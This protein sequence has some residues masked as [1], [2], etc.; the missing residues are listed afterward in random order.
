MTPPTAPTPPTV[1]IPPVTPTPPTVPIPPV[2]ASPPTAPIPPVAPSPPTSPPAPAPGT[3]PSGLSP[4]S[5]RQ[6]LLRAMVALV[7]TAIVAL[8]IVGWRYLDTTGREQRTAEALDAARARTV[9]VLGYDA[10]T[11]DTDLATARTHVTAPFA[12]RFD[13]LARDVIALTAREQ[14]I[15][16]TAQ[17]ARA[18]VLSSEPDRVTVLLFVDQDT[19]T[20]ADPQPRRSATQVT[21]TMA[22]VDGQWLIADL[23]PI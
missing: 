3:T 4:L 9:A 20:A 7:L 6:M 19:T 15:R 5:T 18:A 12:D 23:T 2:A 21:V 11:L 17:V 22:R 1:P 16:T 14:G 13:A 8:G 10:A